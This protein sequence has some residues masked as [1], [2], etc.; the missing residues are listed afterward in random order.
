MRSKLLTFILLGIFFSTEAQV[1]EDIVRMSQGEHNAYIV[2]ME[3]A[4]RKMVEKTW[5]TYLKEY[6]KVK[7]DKKSK[8]YYTEETDI[9]FITRSED[10]QIF[11]KYEERRD[12]TTGYFFFYDGS[13]FLNDSDYP[14]EALQAE[15]FVE[16]YYY[17]VEKYVINEYLEE[18]EKKLEKLEKSLN[19]LEGKHRDYE[20]DIEKYEKKIVEAEE[21]IEKNLKEQDDQRYAI[22]K[23]RQQ[24]EQVIEN[25]NSV[26][27]N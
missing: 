22:E 19:K 7:H 9:P 17:E 12:Q 2:T 24:V 13:G 23:Q 6:G 21:N 11:L 5:K 15:K 10:L 16:E 8:E 18:E 3:G 25:L 27:K 1:T 20:N 14:E 4:D 26:G